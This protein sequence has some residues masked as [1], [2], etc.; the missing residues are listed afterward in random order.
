MNV[1]SLNNEILI[2]TKHLTDGGAERVL[3]ELANEWIKSGYSVTIV[4]T[5]PEMFS[6][7]YNIS[8]KAR[9][10]NFKRGR[11][12]FLNI[13][14]SVYFM[15]KTMNAH[16]NATV[17]V[18]TK[19][20][21]YIVAIASFFTK[22]R[23]V[24]SERNDPEKSPELKSRRFLRDLIFR[25]ADACVFQTPN[26]MDYFPVEVRKKSVIIPNPINPDLPLVNREKR[27]KRIISACRLDSQKNVP[28]MILA[29]KKLQ[30]FYPEYTLYIYGRGPLENDIRRLIKQEQLEE[31]II[32]PGFS[33]NIYNEMNKSAMFILSSD[34]EGI[35]NS[36]LEALAMGLPTVVTDWPS[37]G[38]RMIIKN[39]Y[40][41][42]LVPVGDVDAMFEGM[43]KILDDEA[44]SKKL[45]ENA[46]NI[47]NSYPVE[48]IAQKW[49]EVM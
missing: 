34:Y 30:V 25:K 43:K 15:I 12:R 7:C 41:G 26:A 39:D 48:I 24:V 5:V 18:F 37:G 10:I 2:T 44:F 20:T 3:V 47:R 38:A 32:L 23:L 46:E 21:M 22:N 28:M 13:I 4:Q 40:N 36:V 42:I 8:T 29:F 45:S 33:D 14:K 27:E 31:K 11:N 17:I 9:F 19:A 1:L 6:N 49:T 35:S 16:K